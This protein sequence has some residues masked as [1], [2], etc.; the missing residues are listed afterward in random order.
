MDTPEF[1]QFLAKFPKWITVIFYLCVCCI[2]VGLTASIVYYLLNTPVKDTFQ[3][4]RYY[5]KHKI[6]TIYIDNVSKI[7]SIRL[8]SIRKS[9]EIKH[10]K[11]LL[12]IDTIRM[13]YKLNPI[14]NVY[15]LNGDFR[16]SNLLD[17]GPI[18]N[19]FY[20]TICFILIFVVTKRSSNPLRLILNFCMAVVMLG[21]YAL[22]KGITSPT[23]LN[24]S[25]K[26]YAFDLITSNV[27]LVLVL[28]ATIVF[29]G[30]GYYIARILL[31]AEAE[32]N[33]KKT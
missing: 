4:L 5:D 29:F 18:Q 31:K 8:D 1:V 25:G 9:N 11:D 17:G 2:L 32:E 7:E 10:E 27:G 24:V 15:E 13:K 3:T 30:L 20:Y 21:L 14:S 28:V 22:V 26:L 23:K 16:G 19:L 33:F 12:E 6:D